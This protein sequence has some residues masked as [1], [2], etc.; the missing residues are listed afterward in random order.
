VAERSKARACFRSLL[1]FR[2][3]IPLEA[4]IFVLSV[5]HSKD[6]RHSQD[7]EDKEIV[8]MKYREQKKKFPMAARFSAPVQTDTGTHP[9]SYTMNTESISW[10]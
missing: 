3:R 8:E 4:W 5:L 6:K 2:I 1:G 10:W 9:A 7:N